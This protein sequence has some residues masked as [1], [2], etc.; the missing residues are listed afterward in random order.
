MSDH[1]FH[2]GL[3]VE[4]QHLSFVFPLIGQQGKSA[5]EMVSPRMYTTPMRWLF[6]ELVWGDIHNKYCRL[7]ALIFPCFIPEEKD[8]SYEDDTSRPKKM[9]KKQES[10]HPSQSLF[11]TP[12]EPSQRM[13]AI[14]WIEVFHWCFMALSYIL[15]SSSVVTAAEQTLR[16]WV[17]RWSRS[18]LR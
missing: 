12:Y 1:S 15:V 7:A 6:Q 10:P 18:Q 17:L 11:F 4:E 14:S 3:W 2:G 5:I 8:S 9:C 16:W 13:R